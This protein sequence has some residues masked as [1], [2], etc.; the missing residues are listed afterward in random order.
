MTARKKHICIFDKS[1]ANITVTQSRSSE[2]RGTEGN[3][4][5]NRDSS[6]VSDKGT[7]KM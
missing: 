6:N 7:D 1:K 2:P 3:L 5:L 4:P